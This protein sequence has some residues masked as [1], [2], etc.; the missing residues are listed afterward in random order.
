MSCDADD[1]HVVV[2][3]VVVVVLTEYYFCCRYIYLHVLVNLGLLAQRLYCLMILHSNFLSFD[4]K[5]N[6]SIDVDVL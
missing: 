4:L 6:P 5:Y 1:F 2:V 3:V